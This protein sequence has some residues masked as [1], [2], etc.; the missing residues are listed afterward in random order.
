MALL[1]MFKIYVAN[2]SFFIL[3]FPVPSSW[4][5]DTSASSN[6]CGSDLIP[7]GGDIFKHHMELVPSALQGNWVA[8]D[9]YQS[10]LY[11]GD[12]LIYN[13]PPLYWLNDHSLLPSDKWAWGQQT[14]GR[15]WCYWKMAFLVSMHC[16]KHECD[17][18]KMERV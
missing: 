5:N 2:L 3:I 1:V 18:L 8:T 17:I 15:L 14:V 10:L 4:R 9:L 12:S 7:S 11:L 13:I 16:F 6:R